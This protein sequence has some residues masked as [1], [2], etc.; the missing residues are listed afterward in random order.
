VITILIAIM[1]KHLSYLCPLI[2]RPMT[3]ERIDCN[4]IRQVRLQ[5]FMSW[6]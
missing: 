4:L 6:R 3:V 5:C 1:H 2:S